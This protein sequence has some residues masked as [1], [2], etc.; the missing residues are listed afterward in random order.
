MGRPM[1]L[2]IRRHLFRS[3]FVCAALLATVA[4]I[5]SPARAAESPASK[6]APAATGVRPEEISDLK[7]QLAV[8]K[9]KLD[10]LE[11]Q[12]EQQATMAL[13]QL[14]KQQAAAAVALKS[15]AATPPGA[16]VHIIEKAGT[17]V[18][19]YG[20]LE[21]TLG[22]VT[23]T[24]SKGAPQI[25]MPVSWFSGNRWGI[26]VNQ[27]LS[28][29][30]ESTQNANSL[31]LVAKLESEFELPS[32]DMDTPGVLFN[33]DA[34]IG[35][36]SKAFGKLTIGRQNA[37]P[38]DVAQIWG[39]P[40]GAAQI[41]TNEGGFSNT[42]N[43]KQ[44]IFYASGGNGA[45]GQG[46]TRYDSAIVWK[47]VFGN[48]LFLSA[49]YNFGDANG[50]G[51]P[52]GSGPISGAEFNR[53]SS[54]AGGVGLNAGRFHTTAFYTTSSVLEPKTVG[55]TNLAHQAES[56]GVGGNYEWGRFRVNTGFINY[57][58][59]QGSLGHRHDMAWTTSLKVTPTKFFDYELGV[60][61][62]YAENAAVNGAGF[63]LRPFKDATAGKGTIY[64]SR[65]TVYGSVL[66]HP[67]PNV[68]LYLA[69]DDL[70]TGGG[71]RDSKGN[72]F[73]HVNELASGVRYKF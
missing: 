32:G 42:N 18:R 59:D 21:A 54:V 72:G 22:G 7:S 56:L 62:F 69:A 1:Y 30:E 17:D 12:Q 71:Y 29:I 63:V 41:S 67:V 45:G 5:A 6:P 24:T 28:H 9:A 73:Q 60:Q 57:T 50:P 58:G 65:F 49:A 46:D 2:R 8:M 68:D 3:T 34:W 44:F 35:L 40:Y 37:L 36:Q 66:M 52:N 4:T 27:K 26:D 64:G 47:K 31:N 53:G 15:R 10:L 16:G 43:F 25:G 13:D 61:E 14:Q 39:D 20:L 70:L 11:S 19:L 33:R 23:N 48:G 55:D 38:R 51:G